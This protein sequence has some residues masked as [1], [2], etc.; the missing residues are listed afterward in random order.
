VTKNHAGEIVYLTVKEELDRRYVLTDQSTEINLDKNEISETYQIGDR[1]KV[2]LFH[3]DKGNMAATT[4]I[5]SVQFSTFDWVEVVGVNKN[6]GVFVNIGIPKDLLVSID[7]LPEHQS[8]WPQIGDELYVSLK[9]DKKNRLLADPVRE[10]DFE[11]NWDEAP[12]SLFNQD[13]KGRVFRS[14]REGAVIITEDGYRGFIHHSECK[15]EPR[16]GEWVEGRV[17]KVKQDGTLNVS[18]LP[19]KQDAQAAD[20]ETILAHLKENKGEIPFD[21]QSDP[22]EIRKTF[23]MSKSAFKRAIGKLY[24]ERLIRQEQGKTVLIKDEN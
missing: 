4:K 2:F 18:L 5:P 3:D 19:R 9:L 7:D 13:I 15:K 24:K 16:V 14:G 22:E 12:D 21:N 23:Q 11:D 20:A 8:V 10:V 6:L 1:V 17:I